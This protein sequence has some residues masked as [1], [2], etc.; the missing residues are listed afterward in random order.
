MLSFKDYGLYK[1]MFFR[2]LV[3]KGE[4]IFSEIKNP[5]SYCNLPKK[6]KAVE[7]DINNLEYTLRKEL[8]DNGK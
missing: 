5:D 8:K 4:E 6:R 2:S 1:E 3:K 7:N